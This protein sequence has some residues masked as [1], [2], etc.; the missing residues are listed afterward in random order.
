[1][2]LNRHRR[3]SNVVLTVSD[4]FRVYFIHQPGSQSNAAVGNDYMYQFMYE[5][6]VVKD[7]LPR[8]RFTQNYYYYYYYYFTK[9]DISVVE[10]LIIQASL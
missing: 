5:D 3:V 9:K 7:I 10:V 4:R 2:N 8:V 1:M 6:S